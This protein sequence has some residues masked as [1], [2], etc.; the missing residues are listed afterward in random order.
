MARR[1]RENAIKQAELNREILKSIGKRGNS[2]DY[3]DVEEYLRNRYYDTSRGYEPIIYQQQQ[4]THENLEA[5]KAE[6]RQQ[7]HSS[8]Q[9]LSQKVS[10]KIETPAAMN[11]NVVNEANQNQEQVYQIF[12]DGNNLIDDDDEMQVKYLYS[13]LKNRIP[14]S[15]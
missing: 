13:L 11:G 4:P 3:N 15:I 10:G 9:G 14:N 7:Q 1:Q 12:D 2:I 6:P 8:P 5:N